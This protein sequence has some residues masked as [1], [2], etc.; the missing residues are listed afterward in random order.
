M[1]MHVVQLKGNAGGKVKVSR[2]LV[3]LHAALDATALGPLGRHHGGK[4]FTI[5]LF[6]DG[7][8]IIRQVE[9]SRAIRGNNFLTRVT[10]I[11]AH[12][13]DGR[14]AITRATFKE[15]GSNA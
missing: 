1:G 6:E 5:T 15:I 12:D 3:D 4:V 11:Q 2:D 13:A 9:S 14:G 7:H 10:A 8:V